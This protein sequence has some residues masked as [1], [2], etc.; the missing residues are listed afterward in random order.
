MK[1]LFCTLLF[2]LTPYFLHAQ[3]PDWQAYL[4]VDQT[5]NGNT[6][7]IWF[8]LDY[9]ATNGYDAGLDFMD[10]IFSYPLAIRLQNGQVQ[11]DSNTCAAN[12]R[13]DIKAFAPEVTWDVFV[14]ADT[15]T[16]D[17]NLP[18]DSNFFLRWDTAQFN[19]SDGQYELLYAYLNTS[20]GYINGID[21]E[22][23]CIST[24][25]GCGGSSGSY[26]DAASLI[27]I[28]IQPP[29]YTSSFCATED[30][31]FK[32]TLHVAFDDLLYIDESEPDKIEF[33]N[34]LQTQTIQMSCDPG[35]LLDAFLYDFSGSLQ[36]KHSSSY[37]KTEFHYNF[38]P[39]GIYIL[40]ATLNGNEN[41]FYKFYKF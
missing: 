30:Q 39:Q 26:P 36:W 20:T 19:Y 8:G 13:R 4:L 6:D 23:A 17:E 9:D 3:T 40:R 34:D 2:C 28:G 32:F 18:I 22:E 1:I 14:K 27:Y 24:N 15:F 10:T 7:T 12:M 25:I 37:W 16:A 35:N 29:E 38:L 5:W 11:A 41:Y 21:G 31:I 33:L